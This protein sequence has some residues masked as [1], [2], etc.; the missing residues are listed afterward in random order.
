M[1]ITITTTQNQKNNINNNMTRID[2]GKC[3]ALLRNYYN[4]SINDSLYIKK[5]DIEQNGMKTLKV[6]Y[7]VYAKLFKKNLIKLNLTICEKNKISILIP[8][9]INDHIDKFNSSSGYYNDI[10]YTT[11]T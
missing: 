6:E 1:I 2:L 11:T 3:E 4:I 8:I 10:C 7:E 9:V 5:I